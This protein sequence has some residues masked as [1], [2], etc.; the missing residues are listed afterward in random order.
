MDSQ[1]NNKNPNNESAGT[2]GTDTPSTEPDILNRNGVAP[3]EAPD[4]DMANGLSEVKM[5]NSSLSHGKTIT[6]DIE[7]ANSD[8]N[9]ANSYEAHVD[10]PRDA[11]ST[12]ELE[13]TE[14]ADGLDTNTDESRPMPVD[15]AQ[16]EEVSAVEA[17]SQATKTGTQPALDNDMYSESDQPVTRVSAGGFSPQATKS[18]WWNRK[19]TILVAVIAVVIVVLFGGT[20]LAYKVW[21]QAPSKVLSDASINFIS[22]QSM[23]YTGS[24]NVTSGTTKLALA[25]D[26]GGSGSTA[27]MNAVKV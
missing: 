8:E 7:N 27:S 25:M 13:G 22:A 2:F 3:G 26:G 24:L 16:A 11:E 21:Y 23:T 10:E 19:H 9:G 14:Q 17:E 18:K 20:A 5:S 12:Q 4:D 1:P 15:D 6:P